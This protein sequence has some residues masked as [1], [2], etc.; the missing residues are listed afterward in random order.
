MKRVLSDES[1]PEKQKISQ[2]P[3]CE[4]G[5]PRKSDIL[6]LLLDAW[7]RA[8]L[9][10]VFKILVFVIHNVEV[11][12]NDDLLQL[13]GDWI[14][15]GSNSFI[16][17]LLFEEEAI[18]EFPTSYIMA[19]ILCL[20]ALDHRIQR[21]FYADHKYHDIFGS[22]PP[23]SEILANFRISIYRA[24]LDYLHG[25]FPSPDEFI[26]TVRSVHYMCIQESLEKRTVLIH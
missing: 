22:R 4:I 3:G 25:K 5:T 21:F 18:S 1:E 14:S 11:D 2:L 24:A 15:T 13:P 16:N 12:Y 9:I 19:S 8:R 6:V 17:A 10:R 7:P 26:N 23:R 20:L